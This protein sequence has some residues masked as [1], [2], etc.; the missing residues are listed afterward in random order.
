MND[1][2]KINLIVKPNCVLVAVDNTNYLSSGVDLSNYVSF[3]FLSYA[4]DNKVLPNSIIAHKEFHNRDHYLNF[5]NSEFHLETDGTYSYY[6]LVIPLVSYFEDEDDLG[7]YINLVDELFIY[8]RKLY[9]SN[10]SDE[11]GR[12]IEEVIENSE[13]ITDYIEAY[14]IKLSNKASQTLFS[15]KINVFSV[16]N[17]QKCLVYLQRELLKNNCSYNSCNFNEQIRNKRDFLLGA[18]Y[19]FDYLKDLGNFTEAQRILDNLSSCDSLCEDMDNSNN[20]CGCGNS[21][22]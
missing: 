8:D 7:K 1:L 21:I 18:M 2:L 5:F 9:K 4:D 17:L 16:C 22:S 12:S 15:P 14:N 6:K 13:E 10:I 20:N 19:V 3:E 11:E